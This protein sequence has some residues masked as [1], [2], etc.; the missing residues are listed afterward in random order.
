M[1]IT[2]VNNTTIDISTAE[3]FQQFTS[4]IADIC[5]D[6]DTPLRAYVDEVCGLMNENPVT[7]RRMITEGQTMLMMPP[8]ACEA[9]EK[10]SG[11]LT[12]RVLGIEGNTVLAL[13]EE[14]IC[15]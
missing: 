7:I 1:K 3:L 9:I 10:A 2:T 12:I 4:S 6:M 15:Y 8:A 11:S 5:S 13:R 14:E